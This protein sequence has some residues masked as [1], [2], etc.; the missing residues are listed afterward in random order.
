M[1][2]KEGVLRLRQELMLEIP[3]QMLE[4]A[5]LSVPKWH[6][7]NG[8]GGIVRDRTRAS[9][10]AP[11]EPLPIFDL[12]REGKP[13][14]DQHLALLGLAPNDPLVVIGARNLG[15]NLRIVAYKKEK[16][17]LQLFGEDADKGDRL[18]WCLCYMSQGN[19]EPHT[20]KFK[21]GRISAI[22]GMCVEFG[23]ETGIIWALS[24]QPLLWEGRT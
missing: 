17:L 12:A 14:Y 7:L 2:G 10:R 20:L 1:S 3:V 21:E 16:G 4:K 18:Y 15:N 23:S 6:E 11:G 22:D 5:F 24:G 8:R 19:L 9:Q 13:A